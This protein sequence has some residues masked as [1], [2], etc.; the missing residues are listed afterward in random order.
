MRLGGGQR[1]EGL[2]DIQL[3]ADSAFET[4][5]GQVEG[6]LIFLDGATLHVDFRI[7]GT[8]RKIVG[9]DIGLQGQQDI[10]IIGQTG[11]RLVAR[12]L[13]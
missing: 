2:L 11:L 13:E 8:Q 9:G 12:L 6:R 5:V 1:G 3:R 10:F 7:G 4:A